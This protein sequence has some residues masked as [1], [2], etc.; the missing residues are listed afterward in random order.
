MT[1]LAAPRIHL[2]QNTPIPADLQPTVMPALPSCPADLADACLRLRVL[3]SAALGELGR[4]AVFSEVAEKILPHVPAQRRRGFRAAV[5]E[6]LDPCGQKAAAARKLLD[7]PCIGSLSEGMLEL[8]DGALKSLGARAVVICGEGGDL[9]NQ[10]ALRLVLHTRHL[11]NLVAEVVMQEKTFYSTSIQN[12]SHLQAT[13][14]R[15]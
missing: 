4:A 12:W 13:L 7:C 10:A 2:A 9:E 8:A 14:R 15:I 3:G 6:L 11:Q 5:A 1:P